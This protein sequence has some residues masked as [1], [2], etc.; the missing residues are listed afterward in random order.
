MYN[1][2]LNTDLYNTL[3][4]EIRSSHRISS[5]KKAVA[6]QICKVISLHEYRIGTKNISQTRVRHGYS[7]LNATI[8]SVSLIF[9][10]NF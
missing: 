7:T 9:L 10:P 8:I 1:I 2:H 4:L 6:H 5:F 3:V